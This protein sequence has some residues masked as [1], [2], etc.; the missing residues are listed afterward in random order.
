MILFSD[1]NDN[2]NTIVAA[3][4]QAVSKKQLKKIPFLRKLLTESVT[5]M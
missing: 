1:N 2:N 5:V 4:D 3:Q